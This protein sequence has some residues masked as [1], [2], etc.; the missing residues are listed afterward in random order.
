MPTR[1]ELQHLQQQLLTR[2]DL[3]RTL[4]AAEETPDTTMAAVKTME[5]IKAMDLPGASGATLFMAVG[6]YV[7]SG[8]RSELDARFDEINAT[9]DKAWEG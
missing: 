2:A 4:V 3:W 9:V 7:N 1:D 6:R 5:S 8:D